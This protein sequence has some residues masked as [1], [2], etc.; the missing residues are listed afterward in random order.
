MHGKV[1]DEITYPFPNFSGCTV[2]VC[3]WINNFIP[4]FVMDVITY[5]AGVKG[6]PVSKTNRWSY[7]QR[8]KYQQ[9]LMLTEM[10][11][12]YFTD[13]FLL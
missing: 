5:P 9:N 8:V 3:E 4:H 2:N 1:S 12:D 13:V 7:S 10:R 11:G 6:I